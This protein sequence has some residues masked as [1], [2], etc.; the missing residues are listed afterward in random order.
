VQH[1]AQ[2]N[3]RKQKFA[4]IT[5]SRSPKN[6]DLKPLLNS[7][8]EQ[9]S[10]FMQ[11]FPTEDQ[12]QKQ[13]KPTANVIVSLVEDDFNNDV[14]RI[15][16]Q[17]DNNCCEKSAISI[18][19][20]MDSQNVSSHNISSSHRPKTPEKNT[21]SNHGIDANYLSPILNSNVITEEESKNMTSIS[22]IGFDYEN[23]MKMKEEYIF[24]FCTIRNFLY[25]L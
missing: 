6:N 12:R 16:F 13:K 9:E 19:F 7:K 2:T 17:I 8:L 11:K 10:D 24:V 23:L 25:M 15:P 4:A 18:Q 1:S 5:S 22:Q 14:S 20:D 3:T 21:N